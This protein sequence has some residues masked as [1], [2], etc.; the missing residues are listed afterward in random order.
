MTVLLE[1]FRDV[2]SAVL[3]ITVIVVALNFTLTPLEGHL[4]L[5]FLL[6]SAAIILGLTAF[7]FG[8]DIGVTPIGNVMGASIAKSNKA[9]V[10][11]AAG[12]ALGFMISIAEPD[13]HILATEVEHVTLGVMSKAGLVSVVSVGIAVLLTVGLLRIVL[14]KRLNAL[15]LGAYVI[16]AVFALFSSSEFLAIAFDASGAT[17]GAMTVPFMLS[18]AVGVASLKKSGI[19]SEAD[20]F[21][22][23]GVASAGAILAVLC[24]GVISG[25]GDIAGEIDYGVTA[26]TSIISPFA[27]ALPGI[28]RD[29]A[30]ALAPLTAVFLISQGL[31]FHMPAR[32][33]SRILKGLVYTFFG[34]VTFM[35]GVNAGFMD[36]GT[37]VGNRV[38]SLDAKWIVVAVGFVLGMVV[39]LAEPAVYVLTRQVEEVTSGYVKRKLVLAALSLGIGIAV[40]LSMVR[41]VIPEV[42][43][44]HFLLPGYVISLALAFVVPNLFVGVAFDAGGVAS[45]PMTA[46]FI[47]AFAHGAADAVEGASVMIDGFGVIA[48]VAMMPLI[49]LQ[50]LGLIFKVKSA[51]GGGAAHEH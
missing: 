26:S 18:L 37:I 43:L 24:M 16:I 48:M 46:T 23:V 27:A 19:A 35:L 25:A 29:V 15:L 36:V 7:L 5:R 21:G 45:G 2:I 47:L 12:L 1:K 17:T 28:V 3:P 49:A 9:W 4:L 20:S 34:L 14:M 38:A 50:L 8:V 22:L 39:V 41:I 40:A 30:I 10:V 42:K 44:W 11:V 13:L 33:L 32:S 51:K 31:W 6:G